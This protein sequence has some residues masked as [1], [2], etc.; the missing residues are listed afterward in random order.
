MIEP[1]RAPHTQIRAGLTIQPLA[2]TMIPTQQNK[3]AL[4]YKWPAST[5]I[6][7][8]VYFSFRISNHIEPEFRPLLKQ[9]Q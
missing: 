4:M 9:A 1:S 7:S 3:T 2:Q 6:I 5:P 8:L